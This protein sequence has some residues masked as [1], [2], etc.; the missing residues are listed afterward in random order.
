MNTNETPVSPNDSERFAQKVFTAIGVALLGVTLAAHAGQGPKPTIC[1]RSCWGARASSGCGSMSSL[2]RAIIHHTA[3]ASDFTTSYETGKAKVRGVQNLHMDGNGWCD[4][5]YHFLVNGGGHIY[6]GRVGSMTGLTRGAHD[7]CNDNSFGFNVLGYYHPPYNHNFTTAAQA[8]LEAVIAWRMPSSWSAS[9][10]G[11]YCGNSVGTL[12]GHYKVKSTACPG[13]GIIP[14]IPSIRTGV[15]NRKNGGG[16]TVASRIDVFVRA[17]DNTIRYKKWEQSTGWSPA[18]SFSNLGGNAASDPSA[19]SWGPGRIDVFYRGTDNQIYQRYYSGGSWNPQWNPMGGSYVGSPDACSYA[20]GRLDVFARGVNGTL[21]QKYHSG[22]NWS[23]WRQLASNMTMTSDPSAVC[24]GPDRIDVFARGTAGDLIHTWWDGTAWHDWQSLGGSGLVGGPDACSWA[25][26]RM[27]VFIRDT[28]G[29]MRQK[30]F[31][32]TTWSAAF[33]NLGGAL[34][35]DPGA[36]SFESGR[37]DIFAAGT[38]SSM[39]QRYFNGDWNPAWSDHGGTLVGGVD[40]C[41]WSNTAG[42]R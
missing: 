13:D 19:C 26:R 22:G 15:T 37:L 24:W 1:T 30:Y 17:T 3:G 41:S 2:T 12:D 33:S 38:G 18:T 29:A 40:A 16:G 14:S 7:G 34:T 28:T 25:Y 5:A 27:D 31:E 4:I 9:G 11:S 42:T 20:P 10:S 23:T 32:G 6:E 39:K 35:S 36:C 8:S 21:W